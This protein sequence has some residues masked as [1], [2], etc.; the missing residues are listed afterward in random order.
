MGNKGQNKYCW[1]QIFQTDLRNDDDSNVFFIFTSSGGTQMLSC[2]HT[3]SFDDEVYT[4]SFRLFKLGEKF[5]FKQGKTYYVIGMYVVLWPH[6]F[7]RILSFCHF[8]PI[9]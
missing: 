4:F 7:F 8:C 5:A 2:K 3:E 6:S 1:T 9:S